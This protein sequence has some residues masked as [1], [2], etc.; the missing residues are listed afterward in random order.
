M[1]A[2]NDEDGFYYKGS[3]STPVL[4]RTDKLVWFHG[5]PPKMVSYINVIPIAGAIPWGLL[6]VND[7]VLTRV[8]DS[9]GWEYY[10]P[11]LVVALPNYCHHGPKFYTI[12]IYTHKHVCRERKDIVLIGKEQYKLILDYIWR[13]ANQNVRQSYQSRL[14]RQRRS[15]KRRVVRRTSTDSAVNVS[16]ESLLRHLLYRTDR[17][18][19]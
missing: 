18:S 11:G 19:L 1:I 4:D 5:L 14:L 10:V 16:D 6:W 13:V 8:R 12:L 9:Q 15:K 17:K 2:R 7:C 3:V